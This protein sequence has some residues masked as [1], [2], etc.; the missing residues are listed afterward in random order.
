MSDQNQN[1]TQAALTGFGHSVDVQSFPSCLNCAA[2]E[3]CLSLGCQAARRDFLWWVL[4]CET[5]ALALQV[6]R[7]H[8]VKL[9]LCGANKLTGL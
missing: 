8:S 1:V 3:E 7:A 9:R 6:G 2:L 5:L 4:Q